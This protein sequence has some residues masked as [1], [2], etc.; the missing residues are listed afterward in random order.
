MLGQPPASFRSG[1]TSNPVDTR[2]WVFSVLLQLPLSTG[3]VAFAS[4]LSDER[5]GPGQPMLG[6]IE[7][8]R[9]AVSGTLMHDDP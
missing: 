4:T 1:V 5:F 2:S 8:I 9:L 7:S 6:W 3:I